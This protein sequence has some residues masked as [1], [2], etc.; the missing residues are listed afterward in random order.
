MTKPTTTPA[1][2]SE[3]ILEIGGARAL[4]AAAAGDARAI[5]ALLRDQ[6]AHVVRYAMRLCLSPEDAQDATQEVLLA[7]ARYVGAL[8]HVA[9]LST[10]L[11][12]AVRTH[13]TRLARRSLRYVLVADE[14]ALTLEGESPE[15]QLA[16]RQLRHLLSVVL[17]DVDPAYREVILRRDVLGESAAEAASALGI[18][19]DALKSRLHRARSEV[20]ARLL[21]SLGERRR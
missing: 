11:F 6:R 20:R 19:V 9:A 8:R 16:D 15:E 10:W 17:S 13:C 2:Q 12:L 18:S 5:E 1:P 21:A 7:L 3:A 4:E 14:G